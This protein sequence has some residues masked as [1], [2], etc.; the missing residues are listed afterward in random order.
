[1]KQPLLALVLA[2]LCGCT[3][4]TRTVTSP[5]GIKSTTKV[6]TFLTTVQG[7]NDSVAADGSQ[8]TTIANY[9]SDVQAMQ[10]L[11]NGMIQAAKIGAMA[12]G[13]TNTNL[14]SIIAK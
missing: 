8:I 4:A 5:G 10:V 7:F 6:S 13:S 3:T 12:S 11:L 1:V 14:F 2:I 9:A